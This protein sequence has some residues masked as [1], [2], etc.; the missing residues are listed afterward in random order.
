MDF[1]AGDTAQ[2]VR[3]FDVPLTELKPVKVEVQREAL[4]QGNKMQ[5]S[6]TGHLMPSGFH[7]CP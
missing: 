1:Q 3:A 2:S 4:S 7:V 5:V 6:S